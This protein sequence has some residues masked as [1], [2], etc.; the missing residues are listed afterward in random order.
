MQNLF[1]FGN[2]HPKSFS[3][4]SITTRNHNLYLKHLAKTLPWRRNDLQHQEERKV[5]RLLLANLTI[6]EVFSINLDLLGSINEEQQTCVHN[7]WQ[8]NKL[9]M[10]SS[11]HLREIISKD[12]T[13][14]RKVGSLRSISTQ[15]P[16]HY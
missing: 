16:H 9:C 5:N 13:R 4:G 3:Q 12:M 15:F 2:V 10:S 6:R 1:P 8:S 11:C 7:I 14:Q